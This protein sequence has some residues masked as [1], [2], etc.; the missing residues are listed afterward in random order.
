MKLIPG[1][2]KKQEK[3]AKTLSSF[4]YGFFA[5]SS[6]DLFYISPAITFLINDHDRALNHRAT[7]EIFPTL[8][9]IPTS[10]S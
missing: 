7:L 2:P 8:V 5:L 10:T 3:Y 1:L 9:I 4:F 6:Y